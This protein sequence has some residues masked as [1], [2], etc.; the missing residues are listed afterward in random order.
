MEHWEPK[1]RASRY[2]ARIVPPPTSS[3]DIAIGYATAALDRSVPLTDRWNMVCTAARVMG[4]LL[5]VEGVRS[6]DEDLR[7]LK[8]SGLCEMF[9]EVLNHDVCSESEGPAAAI[10]KL[11]NAVE[12]G[13]IPVTDRL[14]EV[15]AQ[16]AIVL[17]A[18]LLDRRPAARP[19][20]L[21]RG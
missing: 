3:P 10:I 17:L 16:T 7:I 6:R 9:G 12:K 1:T 19:Q 18:P 5:R 21:D 11:V 14:V 20:H 8:A 2:L 4:V 15:L 13:E